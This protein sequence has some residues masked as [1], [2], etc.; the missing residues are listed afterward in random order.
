MPRK[1]DVH[2][3]LA[4]AILLQVEQVAPSHAVGQIALS[5]ASLAGV[6]A[7]KLKSR[8]VTISVAGDDSSTGLPSYTQ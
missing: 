1:V 4:V 5:R 6:T 2:R 3:G 8:N 7:V